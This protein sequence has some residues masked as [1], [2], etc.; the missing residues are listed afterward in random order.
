MDEPEETGAELEEPVAAVSLTVHTGSLRGA[1]S[2]TRGWRA[3]DT[4]M[5]DEN[6]KG[7]E[8]NKKG[9]EGNTK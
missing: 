2:H 7:E 1:I 3:G 9:E 8:G 5:S 4:K 6:K